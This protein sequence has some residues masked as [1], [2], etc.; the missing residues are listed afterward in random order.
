MKKL[1]EKKPVLFAVCW[2][3]AYCLVMTAIKGRFGYESVWMLLALLVFAAAITVCVKACRMEARCGLTGWPKKTKRYL[4]FLPMWILATGNLWD[5]F[6]LS[7]PGMAQVVA[8]LSMLAVGYVEEMIF[9]GFLFRAL[10]SR[11]KTAA[12]IVISALTFGMGHIVN[13]LT[14]QAGVDTLIQI[15]FAISWGFILT[16]VFYRCGSLLPCIAAHAM[17]DVFSLFG[18]DGTLAD[19]VYVGATVVVSIAY[20]VYL[21]RLDRAAPAETI[22]LNNNGGIENNDR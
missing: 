19:R 12:A 4:Y 6:A 8:V 1:Y 2:I 3:A 11:E 21:A 9:R 10:L 17:I 16:M 22:P 7:Y 20:C 5:G 15:L 13:L 18:K 14:G